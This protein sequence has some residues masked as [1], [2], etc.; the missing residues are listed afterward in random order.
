MSFTA[1]LAREDAITEALRAI[2][3]AIGD[4]V[5]TVQAFRIIDAIKRL[6]DG[7]PAHV[8]STERRDYLSEG[9][10]A[11]RV[12]WNKAHSQDATGPEYDALIGIDTPLGRLRVTTWRRPWRGDR[13]ERVAW[14]SEYYLNDQPITV[15]E[16]RAMGLAQRPTTRNRK[17]S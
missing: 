5:P 6:R 2:N 14:A 13:G 12:A 17:R 4:E 9:Q 15:A 11:A 10:E 8:G 7:Q 3:D 16:I 1:R